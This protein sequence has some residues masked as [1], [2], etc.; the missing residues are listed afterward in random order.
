M[1]KQYSM[2]KLHETI[3]PFFASTKGEAVKRADKGRGRPVSITFDNCVNEYTRNLPGL[4]RVE[5]EKNPFAFLGLISDSRRALTEEEVAYLATTRDAK[6][7]AVRDGE[8]AQ[9]DGNLRFDIPLA[10]GNVAEVLEGWFNEV[11]VPSVQLAAKYKGTEFGISVERR[12]IERGQRGVAKK[13]GT[14]DLRGL[15]SRYQYAIYATDAVDEA[16]ALVKKGFLTLG[17]VAPDGTVTLTADLRNAPAPVVEAP[18]VEAVAETPAEAPKKVRKP[19]TNKKAAA[20][21]T[22]AQAPVEAV[23]ETP[24]AEVEGVVGEVC[25]A[26]PEAELVTA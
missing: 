25:A 9:A 5:A 4:A 8:P 12:A 1:E 23:A 2:N 18:T 16:G 22:E 7:Q 26:T 21:S 6:Y 10:E 11:V 14:P 17:S 19:R 20:V 13:D 3:A 24:A 15:T